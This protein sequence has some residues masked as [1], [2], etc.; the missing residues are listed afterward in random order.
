MTDFKFSELN[1]WVLKKKWCEVTGDTDAAIAARRRSGWWLNNVHCKVV[2]TS[3]NGTGGR[4][5]INVKAANQ[6]IENEGK[7]ASK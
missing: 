4:L 3:I 2:G 6:W 1:A 5:W 7:G